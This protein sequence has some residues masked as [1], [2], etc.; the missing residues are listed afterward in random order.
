MGNTW[1]QG[2]LRASH[3]YHEV[4]PIEKF[5]QQIKK[6]NRVTYVTCEKQCPV[7]DYRH[8]CRESTEYREQGTGRKKTDLLHTVPMSSCLGLFKDCE[9]ELCFTADWL[10]AQEGHTWC[11][12]AS[13]PI[14][15]AESRWGNGHYPGG[16]EGS[17][18]ILP[19]WLAQAIRR[20]R[21][22]PRKPHN[23]GALVCLQMERL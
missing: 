5:A 7:G 6:N 23:S 21:V 12:Q 10:S 1:H 15:H 13:S 20:H 8:I 17:S 16:N 4:L 22:M 19:G 2:S 11:Y 9:G 14:A 18:G 3:N